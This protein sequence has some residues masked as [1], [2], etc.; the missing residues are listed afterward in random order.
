M[1]NNI[2]T[3]KHGEPA[4]KAVGESMNS[5]F[6][7]SETTVGEKVIVVWQDGKVVAKPKAGLSPA[8]SLQVGKAIEKFNSVSPGLT[9]IVKASATLHNNSDYQAELDNYTQTLYGVSN[10][11]N[12]PVVGPTEEVK[13][14]QA[15]ENAESD[16]TYLLAQP[17]PKPVK[18]SKQVTTEAS[19]SSPSSKAA[20]AP[21]QAGTVKDNTSIEA[22]TEQDVIEI[23][24]YPEL[25]EAWDKRQEQGLIQEMMAQ[26]YKPADIQNA[27]DIQRKRFKELRGH[28]NAGGQ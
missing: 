10:I 20:P 12:K 11:S 17:D 18:P 25:V 8:E 5:Y 28:A 23:A 6:T 19:P 2:I 13:V 9:A 14:N 24:A 26:G 27:L 21:Q 22:A 4:F 16:L 1:A 3:K 7:G 15:K